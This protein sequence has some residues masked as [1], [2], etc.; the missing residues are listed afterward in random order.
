VHP[1]SDHLEFPAVSHLVVLRAPEEEHESRTTGAAAPGGAPFA[2]LM[3]EL[4]ARSQ[5]VAVVEDAPAAMVE[6]HRGGQALVLV[7]YPRSSVVSELILAV[8]RYY[9]RVSLWQAQ[10]ASEQGRPVLSRIVS[11]AS[12]SATSQPHHL[13]DDLHSEAAHAEHREASP[14]SALVSDEELAMLMSPFES[15]S[16][17]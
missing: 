4:M 9:P 11:T 6:L 8:S 5:R 12:V 1:L 13:L 14:T 7:E 10:R 16:D 2:P 17:H 3:L 15:E